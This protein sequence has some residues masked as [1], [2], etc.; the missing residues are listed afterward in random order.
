[1]KHNLLLLVPVLLFSSC[2][3]NA[4]SSKN[5]ET[6][7]DAGRV[8]TSE[9]EIYVADASTYKTDN[10]SFTLTLGVKNLT[11]KH[12]DIMFSNA[13]LL[14]ENTNVNYTV[15][16]YFQYLS[17]DSEIEGK[18]FFYS[19]IPSSL[20]EP[21]C[22]SVSFKNINY[23][24]HLY[25]A[26]DEVRED[27]TVSY[28]ING[29]IV[30]TEIVKKG[31]ALNV[32]YTYDTPDHQ[33]NANLW[34]DDDEKRI[35]VGTIINGNITVHGTLFSNYQLITTTSDPYMLVNYIWHVPSDGAVVIA[36]AYDGKEPT[37][38]NYAIYN[39]SNIKK[40]YLPSTLHTVYSYNFYNCSRLT[41]IYYA[42]SEE[43]WGEIKFTS[44]VPNGI[45]IVFNTP[46]IH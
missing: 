26:P 15:S 23:K 40:V 5:I 36:D 27:V 8:Q 2:S 33:Q 46:F 9:Y 3:P 44:P 1:M 31:R 25:E 12:Q 34:K 10:Y 7:L 17:L 18:V 19:T 14:K 11:K 22:F 45:N 4:N 21:Y 43:Q 41:T 29:E 35:E 6:Y 37:L 30:H 16:S 38:G 20:E 28:E 13:K 24:V 39:N 32:D 42:G